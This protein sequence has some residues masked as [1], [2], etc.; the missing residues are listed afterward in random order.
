MEIRQ[1]LPEESAAVAALVIASD[2]GLLDALFGHSVE[3]LVARLQ[4]RPANPY[5]AGH[6]LVLVESGAAVVGAAVASVAA[7]ARR[8][9]LRTAAALAAWYG[10]RFLRYLP[11]LARAGAA[12][13]SLAPDDFYL[14]HIAVV[15]ERRGAG[16]GAELLRAAERRAR[17]LGAHRLVLDVEEANIGARAFYERMGYEQLS[18]VTIDLGRH[19]RFSFH[20]L[21]R[22]L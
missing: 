19:G 12:T 10:P 16:L 15:A 5:S 8:E 11:R 20:R 14:S 21:F 22:G 4:T 13:A 7:A 1:P 6:T 9:E 2:C 17:L 3:R 18:D